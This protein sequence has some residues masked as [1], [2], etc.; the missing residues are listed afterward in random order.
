L[1]RRVIPPRLLIAGVVASMLPDVDVIGFSLGVPYGTA[2]A[3]RG[4]THAIAFAAAFGVLGA[5]W[6]RPWQ[7]SFAR[8]LAFLFV[9]MASHGLLDACTNGGSGIALLWPFTDV[10]YVAPWRIIE[11]SPIGVS[12]FFSARGATVLASELRWV[13]L[14]CLAIGLV[15]MLVRRNI[16][17]PHHH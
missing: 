4:F 13:W 1:G 12:R 8:A 2:A 5:C 10:R 14:P 11:V 9:A 17:A 16:V 6:F 15:M 7:T 3:H